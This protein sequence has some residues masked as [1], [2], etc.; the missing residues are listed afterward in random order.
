MAGLASVFMTENRDY[1]ESAGELISC[2]FQFPQIHSSL[3]GAG[4]NREF[5]Q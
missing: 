1:A 4:L 2:V 3:I 5:L